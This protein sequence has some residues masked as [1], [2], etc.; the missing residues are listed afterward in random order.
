MNLLNA[1]YTYLSTDGGGFECHGAIRTL[2]EKLDLKHTCGFVTLLKTGKVGQNKQVSTPMSAPATPHSAGDTNIDGS[3]SSSGI[4][5]ST[6]SQSSAPAG[7]EPKSSVSSQSIDSQ[8]SG[9]Q[10]GMDPDGAEVLASELDS[11]DITIEKRT[12]THK[13]SGSPARDKLTLAVGQRAGCSTTE[14]GDQSC[15]PNVQSNWV[16][17]DCCYGIPLFQADVNREVCERVASHGLCSRDRY[18][19]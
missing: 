13:P 16:L 17:L 10:N 18:V 6:S 2:A 4:G 3:S 14:S 5:G 9:P 8:S 11:L 1:F 7:K 19:P 12:P 15:D